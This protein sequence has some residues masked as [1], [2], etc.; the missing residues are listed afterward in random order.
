MVERLDW[1]LTILLKCVHILLI[2]ILVQLVAT[3]LYIVASLHIL[4]ARWQTASAIS[5]H[6]MATPWLIVGVLLAT[7]LLI[8]VDI[9]AIGVL[10]SILVNVTSLLIGIKSALM[11]MCVQILLADQLTTILNRRLLDGRETIIFLLS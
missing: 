8:C 1:V 10:I 6:V 3:R 7:I 11:V 9:I 5:L 4:A 2:G